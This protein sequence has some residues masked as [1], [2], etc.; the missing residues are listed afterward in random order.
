MKELEVGRN[1]WTVFGDSNG[2]QMVYLGGIKFRAI[3]ARTGATRDIDSQDTYDKVSEWI[4]RPS[5][6]MG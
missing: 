6:C 5:V 2:N 3:N 4:N 1:Y